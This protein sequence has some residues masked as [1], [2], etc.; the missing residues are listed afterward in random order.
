M[1]ILIRSFVKIIIT[2]AHEYKILSVG[3]I[4]SIKNLYYILLQY[5]PYIYI[6]INDDVNSFLC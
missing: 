3:H 2:H 1:M 5:H 6:Y 4:L